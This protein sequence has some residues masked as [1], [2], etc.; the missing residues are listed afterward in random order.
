MIRLWKLKSNGWMVREVETSKN[1]HWPPKPFKK[2]Q[3]VAFFRNYELSKPNILETMSFPKSLK[4][5]HVNNNHSLSC[6][7]PI[8][9]RSIKNLQRVLRNL[10]PKVLI[11]LSTETNLPERATQG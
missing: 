10:R 4:S 9:L 11:L 1:C 7:S 8:F 2:K 3:E 6:W 5:R